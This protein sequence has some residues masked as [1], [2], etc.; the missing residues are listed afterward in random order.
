MQR[1]RKTSPAATAV[2]FPSDHLLGQQRSRHR[3]AAAEPLA[4]KYLVTFGI[5]PT[6]PHTGYGYIKPGKSLAI[7]A[8]VEEF[9]EKPDEKTAEA[10]VQAGYLWNSGIFLL[11]TTC[12]F[13][14]LKRYNPGP[15]CSICR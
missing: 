14:E 1:I 11:S 12:F 6:S 15:V 7:G 9:R 13:E 10:Y 3:S 8:V 2:V 4:E 5:R